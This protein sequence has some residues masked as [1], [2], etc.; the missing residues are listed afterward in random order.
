MS[1][2]WTHSASTQCSDSDWSFRIIVRR[3]RTQL[4]SES[5]SESLSEHSVTRTVV[6]VFESSFTLPSTQLLSASLR[7]VLS[8]HSVPKQWLEFSNQCPSGRALSDLT[9]AERR[10]QH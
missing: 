6:G 9:L 10:Q 8:E 1:T 4:L 7:G 2:E 5:L 3:R